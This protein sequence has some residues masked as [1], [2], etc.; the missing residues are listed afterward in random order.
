M[1]IMLNKSIDKRDQYEMI[2]ISE[3][4]ENDTLYFQEE[5]NNEINE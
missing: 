5:L 2:S 1:F 4:A 3:L